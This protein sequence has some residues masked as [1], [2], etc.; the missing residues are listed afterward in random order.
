[1]HFHSRNLILK[2]GNFVIHDPRVNIQ[3]LGFFFKSE[4]YACVFVDFNLLLVNFGLK[5]IQLLKCAL[6]LF[7][8]EKGLLHYDLKFNLET[9]PVFFGI[10][11]SLL[12]LLVGH[13]WGLKHSLGVLQF[14]ALIL[15]GFE[16]LKKGIF[17]SLAWVKDLI[18]D[19]EI[20]FYIF[21]SWTSLNDSVFNLDPFSGQSFYTDVTVGESFQLFLLRCQT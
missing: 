10:C 14:T 15:G 3:L 4:N 8:S 9:V 21:K 19:F 12:N 17:V 18:S 13:S 2:I 11:N 1:M 5:L 16:L 6:V 7:S 20:R